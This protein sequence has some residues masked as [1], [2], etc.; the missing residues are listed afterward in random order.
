MNFKNM[1][2]LKLEKAI[3]SAFSINEIFK[4]C[5]RAIGAL[6]STTSHEVMDLIQKINQEGKTILV[7]THELDFHFC[8]LGTLEIK[9]IDRFLFHLSLQAEYLYLIVFC[10]VLFY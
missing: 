9:L 4:I 3:T 6:D 10:L 1:A 5:S 7:V 8:Q 2:I